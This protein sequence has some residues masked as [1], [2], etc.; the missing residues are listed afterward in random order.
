VLFV[1][2]LAIALVTYNVLVHL[3]PP[4]PGEVVGG[5]VPA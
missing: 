4:R 2:H 1:M 5:P 3:A